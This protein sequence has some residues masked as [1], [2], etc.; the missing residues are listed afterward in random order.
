MCPLKAKTGM[1]HSDSETKANILNEQFSPVFNKDEDIST[2][3]DMGPSPHDPVEY[4]T[5]T[6]GGIEDP[7]WTQSTQGDRS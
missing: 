7:C 1:T 2:I 3:L 4:I 5:V 6:E